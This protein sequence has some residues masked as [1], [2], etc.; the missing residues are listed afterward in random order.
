MTAK[1]EIISEEVNRPGV[2]RLE[3]YVAEMAAGSTM[4]HSINVRHF[5]FLCSLRSGTNEAQLDKVQDQIDKLYKLVKS[6]PQISKA[7][8][9]SIRSL[10]G[11]VVR[12]LGKDAAPPVVKTAARS[13]RP[14]SQFLRPT[15][16]AESTF[17]A[18]DKIPLLHL[19]RKVGT[20]WQYSSKLTSLYLDILKEIATSGVTFEHKNALLTG[21]GKGSIAVE[22]V[23][24]LLAG[25]A[26]VVITTVRS[27]SF[28]FERY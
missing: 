21:V 4:T 27:F 18:E 9:Q 15:A 26:K 12:G 23:K 24:G 28:N 22:I 13:R 17:V 20:N 11:E 3:K 6:Q 14:S 5:S 2:S 16:V 8:M 25:G 1:G 7:H 10:Y 19:K